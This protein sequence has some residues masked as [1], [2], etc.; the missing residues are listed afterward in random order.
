LQKE[1]KNT[2]I[3]DW[4]MK[5]TP[6]HLDPEDKRINN[7]GTLEKIIISCTRQQFAPLYPCKNNY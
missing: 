7:L 1:K 6:S 3:L 4:Y 5:W 2:L